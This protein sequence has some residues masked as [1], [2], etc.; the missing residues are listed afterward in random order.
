MCRGCVK[1]PQWGLPWRQMV[2]VSSPSCS[3]NY[4]HRKHLEGKHCIQ[5]LAIN[6]QLK[7]IIVLTNNRTMPRQPNYNF[8]TSMLSAPKLWHIIHYHILGNQDEEVHIVECK[9]GQTWG[10]EHDVCG[11]EVIFQHAIGSDMWGWV[12]I[13]IKPTWC[14][15]RWD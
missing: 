1:S 12:F 4:Y 11:D 13:T 14:E 6:P 8:H 5:L 3:V 7:N 9:M 2:N 15:V 10:G